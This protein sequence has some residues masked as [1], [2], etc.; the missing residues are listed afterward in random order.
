MKRLSMV[1][2]CLVVMGLVASL[3]LS[4]AQEFDDPEN[5]PEMTCGDQMAAPKLKKKCVP[6]IKTGAS[7]NKKN[8]SND[9]NGKKDDAE[10]GS[11]HR[12]GPKSK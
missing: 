3:T 6:K 1:V 7:I 10:E 5:E 8:D 11:P 12:E 4:Q 9:N 2:F